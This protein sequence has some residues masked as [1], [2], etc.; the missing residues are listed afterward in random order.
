MCSTYKVQLKLFGISFL[1]LVIATVQTVD[2]VVFI[3]WPVHHHNKAQQHAGL[4][5]TT[6]A[7]T[8]R[9]LINKCLKR[10]STFPLCASSYYKLAYT[11]YNSNHWC[12]GCLIPYIYFLEWQTANI[13]VV[14]CALTSVASVCGCV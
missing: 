7:L 14:I 12:L 8:H 13:N 11:Y 4:I 1:Q 2:V 10:S 6:R 5:Y 3:T 9:I